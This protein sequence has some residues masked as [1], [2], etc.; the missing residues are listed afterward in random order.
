[1]KK[2]VMVMSITVDGKDTDVLRELREELREL[3]R[4]LPFDRSKTYSWR[5]LK[6]IPT[7]VDTE[8]SEVKLFIPVQ[9]YMKP[10]DF[11]DGK[12]FAV[13]SGV[14]YTLVNEDKDTDELTYAPIQEIIIPLNELVE[15]V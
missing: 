4:S 14:V 1:M 8:M 2:P 15:G 13:I 7:A 3:V 10:K 11:E 9:E 5:G 12:E 6:V